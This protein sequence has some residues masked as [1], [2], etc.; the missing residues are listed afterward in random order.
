MTT[1]MSADFETMTVTDV[2]VVSPN[3]TAASAAENRTAESE[4]D[5]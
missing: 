2:S 1:A 4:A 3:R 5:E